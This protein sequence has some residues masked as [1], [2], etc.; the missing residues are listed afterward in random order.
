MFRLLK[1]LLI[2]MSVRF[3]PDDALADDLRLGPF[4][5]PQ[6][7]ELS[8]PRGAMR[9]DVR[10]ALH[11]SFS[12][13]EQCAK[14]PDG[15]WVEA[16]GGGD[17]IRYYAA[18]LDEDG[19]S[20]ILVYF[21]GDVILRTSGGMRFISAS[22]G[23]QS[24]DG[25]LADMARWSGQ[26]GL[27]AI[28]VARPGTFG[29]SGSHA[30][31]RHPREVALLDGALDLLKDR[32]GISSFILA[33]QSGGGHIVASLLNRRRDV[34]A[35]VISSGLVSVRQVTDYWDRR[36]KVPDWFLYDVKAYYDPIG[37]VD[38][39]RKDS[40]PQIYVISDPED[41]V[42][43]FASQLRYVRRL[44]AAGF[45]PQHVYAHAP[46]A[47]RHALA[48]NARLA[49]AMIARGMATKDIRRA[50][51]EIDLEQIE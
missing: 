27:P 8:V 38:R 45:S 34:A 47:N 25:I 7:K 37:E 49:A 19:A 16:D 44:R 48:R 36:R 40:P 17:C 21:S 14:V 51:E 24:P 2:F 32:Y 9:F 35:A 5:K 26:A 41:H 42:V 46:D 3:A 50:L 11:G 23:E 22:Y 31:R 12:S 39:I 10:E 33:G 18:G 20:K 15:L 29:S 30:M 1:W 13:P 28:Y 4:E 6:P 43:P